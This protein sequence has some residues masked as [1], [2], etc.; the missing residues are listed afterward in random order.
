MG[1]ELIM[2]V[3]LVVIALIGGVY[4]FGKYTSYKEKIE[5]NKETKN[6]EVS[7]FSKVVLAFILS[8]IIVFSFII[9]FQLLGLQQ[10]QM[11]IVVVTIIVF[12]MIMC[13]YS[14]IEE[15][16]KLNDNKK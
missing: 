5:G 8:F 6:E 14:I 12:T 11:G 10:E 3:I 2:E 15:I 4:I 9:L 13:T 7:L 1:G 16:R